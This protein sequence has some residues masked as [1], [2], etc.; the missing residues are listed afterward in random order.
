MTLIASTSH[1]PRLPPTTTLDFASPFKSIVEADQATPYQVPF[2]QYCTQ[3]ASWMR[4]NR[5]K[6]LPNLLKR[7]TLQAIFRQQS[8]YWDPMAKAHV[9]SC[10]AAALDFMRLA[11]THVAG[12][13]TGQKLMQE[14]VNPAFDVKYAQLHAKVEEL[15]W[16]YQKCHL[17]TDN[18]RW[19]TRTQSETTDAQTSESQL[20]WSAYVASLPQCSKEHRIAAE[21]M[22]RAD[23]FYDVRSCVNSSLRL[24]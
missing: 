2:E 20:P 9:H 3:L 5:G 13:H 14:Y 11:V 24:C 17:I 12:R 4:E 6:D 16:P 7:D 21:A 19:L 18:P 15:L 23:V 22:D 1:L 10:T 8:I